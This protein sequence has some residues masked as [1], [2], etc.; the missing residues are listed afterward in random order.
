MNQM[1]FPAVLKQFF[2]QH[3][4]YGCLKSNVKSACNFDYGVCFKDQM[5]MNC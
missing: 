1:I 2:S 3:L 4:S 5:E